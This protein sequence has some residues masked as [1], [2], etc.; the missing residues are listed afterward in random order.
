MSADRAQDDIEAQQNDASVRDAPDGLAFDNDYT[1]RVG[2]KQAPIPVQ[3]DAD[4]VADNNPDVDDPD[5]DKALQQDEAAAIDKSNIMNNRTRGGR[6]A[7]NLREPSDEE[8]PDP[9]VKD[10]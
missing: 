8:F 3:S 2:Q 7:G 6:T 9:K 4:A 5:S 10:M 1:S